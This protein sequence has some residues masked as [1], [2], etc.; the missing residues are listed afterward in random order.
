VDRDKVNIIQP[1]FSFLFFLAKE[2]GRWGI[3]NIPKLLFS[4]FPLTIEGGKKDKKTKGERE[5]R[6]SLDWMGKIILTTNNRKY[7][8]RRGEKREICPLHARTD[9]VE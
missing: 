3:T 5:R 4:F 7:E 8:E 9:G 2:N 6:A 1:H